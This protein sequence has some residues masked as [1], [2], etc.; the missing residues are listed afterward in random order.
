[1]WSKKLRSKTRKEVAENSEPD[2]IAA[3]EFSSNH[4]P[5]LE[6]DRICGCFCCLEI[7]DPQEIEEWIIEDTPIDRRGTAI[8][9]RCG[10]DSVIGESSG[11]PI[12]REF[13]QKMNDCW[14]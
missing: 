6:K 3:H 14:F 12:T 1:M 13:L 2:F 5:E 10:I 7:F 8:C 4:K 11:Y 9:P